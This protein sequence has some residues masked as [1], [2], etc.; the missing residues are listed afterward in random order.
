MSSIS[1]RVFVRQGGLSLLAL[2]LPPEFV[3]RS[4]LAKPRGAAKKKT[5]ICIFQ[6]GAVDGLNMVV[7]FGE[8]SYYA[9]RRSIAVPA[10]TR[11]NGAIDLDG[12]FGLHPTLKPLHELFSRRELAIVHAVGSPHPTRSHFDAQDYM[13]TATPGVKSTRDGWLNRTLAHT[14]CD[15]T[16]RTLDDRRAHAADHA[17]GQ[18]AMATELPASLRGIAL[19]AALPR[20]MRGTHPTLAIADLD[21]FG[22]AGGRDAS[23]EETFARVYGS[24]SGSVVA[25]AADDAFEA[26]R[27]LKA[28]NLRQYAPAAGI[29]YPAGNFG[30][31]LRQ[32]AQLIKADVG[33]E[34]AFA[35]IGGWDTHQAQGGAQGQLARRFDELARGIRALY[36]DLGDRMNDVVL[37]TMSEFGRTVAENGS[38]GT[39]HGH[40]NCMMVMGGAVQGGRILGEWPGLEPEQLYERRDLALTT[41]FRDVFA[42]VVAKHLGAEQLGEI[43]P[44][45]DVDPGRWRGVLG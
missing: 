18:I 43:F 44:G 30:R 19:G 31:S 24:E 21:R 23:L 40:A 38:G 6:R 36:D 4:L 26:I 42:E 15:C 33:V 5:L 28:T 22:I 12:F 27:I 37:V 45:H 29:E 25:D 8:P 3:T 17:T 14:D 7:P 32:V 9:R 10:P 2:G 34:I 11:E 20:S 16:G 1:R 13:E 35:D 39:D 41:D